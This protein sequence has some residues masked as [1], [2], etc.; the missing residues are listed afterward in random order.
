VMWFGIFGGNLALPDG[1]KVTPETPAFLS[2][3]PMSD[4]EMISAKVKASAVV[5]VFVWAAVLALIGVSMLIPH[6]NR[7]AESLVHFLSR[8]ATPRHA[9]VAGTA[10][11][12]LIILSWLAALKSFAVTLYGR[13][14]ITH[15]RVFG[16]ILLIGAFGGA[17]QWA[18]T[19]RQS[20]VLPIAAHMAA[21]ALIA[22][23]VGT[24]VPIHFAIR[25][26]R[27][28][29]DERLIAWT[30]IWLLAAAML[31]GVAFW[32]VPPIRHSPIALVAC[33]ALVLPYNRLIAMPLA[34]HLNRHR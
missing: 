29:N 14:W 33:I 19:H 22:A 30:V 6:G 12:G 26:R 4:R 34:W 8:H 2:A 13:K 1:W 10:L 7:Q 9:L 32:L 31:F 17:A 16:S 23:K 5:V 3:R 27:I 25:R 15:A 24:A 18:W 21:W 11:A 20:Q 28:A